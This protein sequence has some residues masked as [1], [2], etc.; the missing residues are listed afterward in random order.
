MTRERAS[1]RPALEALEDRTTPMVAAVFQGQPGLW[2]WQGA[3]WSRL[4]VNTPSQV[5]TSEFGEV[6]ADFDSQGLWYYQRSCGWVQATA[7]DPDLI[8]IGNNGNPDIG[9]NSDVFASFDGQ[10]LWRAHRPNVSVPARWQWLTPTQPA[11]IDAGITS[12]AADFNAQGLWTW[13]PTQGWY[14]AAASDPTDLALCEYRYV[15]Y[16]NSIP[17]ATSGYTLAAAFGSAGLWTINQEITDRGAVSVPQPPFDATR[18]T[19]ISTLNPSGV[20]A[21]NRGYV[22]AAFPGYGLLRYKNEGLTLWQSM[23][24]NRVTKIAYATSPS[25]GSLGP[26]YAVFPDG[27]LRTQ[28]TF[29]APWEIINGHTPAF[30]A[31]D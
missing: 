21:G 1:A 15:W 14:K 2:G 9:I 30:Y 20:D 22:L 26:A 25:A 19:M 18:W 4:A 12:L 11:Q 8:A 16:I 31:V 7:N 3:G 27:S 5:V 10:G 24:T 6:L 29:G 28:T 23:T 13:S 17:V